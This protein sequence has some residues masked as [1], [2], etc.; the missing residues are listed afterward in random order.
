MFG[1]EFKKESC[2][3]VFFQQYLKG[4]RYLTILTEVKIEFDS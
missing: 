1:A 3:T 4:E 2:Y